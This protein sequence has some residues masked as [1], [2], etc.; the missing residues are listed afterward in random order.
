MVKQKKHKLIITIVAKG[1]SDTIVEA[2]KEAGARGG[3]IVYGRGS[4]V[5]E[6]KKI[7]SM[8][9][10]P[11]KDVVLTIVEARQADDVLQH[12][13][14]KSDLNQPGNGIAFMLD[15]DAVSQDL[16]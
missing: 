16:A 3:T 1:Q 7:F 15:V 10:E 5:H 9:I 8:L 13:V 2:S 4:G 12:I 11:E 6:K 14:D